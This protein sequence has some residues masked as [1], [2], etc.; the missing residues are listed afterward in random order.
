MESVPL[1]GMYNQGGSK[2]KMQHQ[3]SIFFELTPMVGLTKYVSRCLTIYG[4]AN[5]IFG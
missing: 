2:I 3:G 1:E 4:N 5:S